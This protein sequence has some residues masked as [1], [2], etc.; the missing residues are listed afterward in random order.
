MI[1]EGDQ[2]G[3]E[4]DAGAM[5]ACAMSARSAA[6]EIDPRRHGYKGPDGKKRNPNNA[7]RHCVMTCCATKILGQRGTDYMYNRE[8]DN[9]Y[10]KDVNMDRH[11]K[12]Q[13]EYV[14]NCGENCKD[15]CFKRLI[16]GRLQ[17][18]E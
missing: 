17:I 5:V 10:P 7:M 8:N 6:N 14:A 13:G 11:N 4:G 3:F 18:I 15:G 1:I 2:G 9:P 16:S 12:A